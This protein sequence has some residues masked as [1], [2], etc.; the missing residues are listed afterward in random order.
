[1]GLWFRGLVFDDNVFRGFLFGTGLSS[2][3]SSV[4][5]RQIGRKRA[6]EKRKTLSRR[7]YVMTHGDFYLGKTCVYI[8]STLPVNLNK[9]RRKTRPGEPL[10]WAQSCIFIKNSARFGRITLERIGRFRICKLRWKGIFET[11]QSTLVRFWIRLE[12]KELRP[13]FGRKCSSAHRRGRVCDAL[14]SK[15]MG[16]GTQKFTGN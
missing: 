9:I 11:F 12:T 16:V 14:A 4:N 8:I 6:Q 1:M 5:L 2:G 10:V 3:L 7:H 13:N 15:P